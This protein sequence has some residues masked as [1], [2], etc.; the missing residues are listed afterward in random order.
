MPRVESSK[1]QRWTHIH[2]GIFIVWVTIAGTLGNVETWIY[3][4]T[5]GFCNQLK[6][7]PKV[8]PLPFLTFHP[9]CTVL[10]LKTRNT[11]CV[12]IKRSCDVRQFLLNLNI[13]KFHSSLCSCLQPA[14]N[15]EEGDMW[16]VNC[17]SMWKVP[18]IF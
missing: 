15:L 11:H 6:F 16:K 13:Y 18:G 9:N 12:F 5:R 2:L 1:L 8:T 4:S 10:L 14:H 7:L 3:I 17:N